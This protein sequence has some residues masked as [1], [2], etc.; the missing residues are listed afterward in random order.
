MK[1][2]D[3]VSSALDVLGEA[4]RE[5]QIGDVAELVERHYPNLSTD[6]PA[7][8]GVIVD[9]AQ[10]S[11]LG[12]RLRQAYPEEHPVTAISFGEAAPCRQDVTLGHLETIVPGGPALLY[13]PP[14]PWA[15]AIETFQGTVAHL[16][17]PDG[18]PWDR[19][20]TH[21]SLRQGFQE[22][23]YEVLDALDRGDLEALE[24]ELG[25]VLL[26][27]LLQAQIA[28]EHGEFRMSDI[29]RRVNEKI[30]YRHP[31]VFGGLDVDG[32]EAVLVNWEALK[33]QE[34]ETRVEDASAL[35][36]VVRGMPA[37]ARAQSIQRHVDRTGVV[38]MGNDDLIRHIVDLVETLDASQGPDVCAQGLGELLFDVANLARNLGVDAESALREANSRFEEHFRALERGAPKGLTV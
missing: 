34:K 14:L 3:L 15:G 16:R 23:A 7:L 36:G 33:Q 29:V 8:L 18:C 17:A 38:S 12:A 28:T 30:I 25:D 22:E 31:H 6:R 13:V 37:L 10:C 26:H 11:L 24:E 19:K 35:D 20:Q 32:V 21:R 27:V 2:Y 5:L 4:P 1:V 9:A